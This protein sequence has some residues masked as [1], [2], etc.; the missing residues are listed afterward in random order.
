MRNPFKKKPEV[1]GVDQSDKVSSKISPETL[2]IG[3]LTKVIDEKFETA[4]NLQMNS[5]SDEYVEGKLGPQ[6]S[7]EPT[8]NEARDRVRERFREE[9]IESTKDSNKVSIWLLVDKATIL[10]IRINDGDDTD[11]YPKY[12]FIYHGKTNDTTS[13]VKI[14]AHFFIYGNKITGP[15]GELKKGDIFSLRKAVEDAN[16]LELSKVQDFLYSEIDRKAAEDAQEFNQ[17]PED[18]NGDF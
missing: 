17:N 5:A 10:Q 3:S 12:E 13:G 1:E 4:A 7:Y 16:L 18:N 2:A 9:Q 11:I 8:G 6:S 14:T 15:K